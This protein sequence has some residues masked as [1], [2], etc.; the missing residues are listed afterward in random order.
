[1]ADRG[2]IEALI[3]TLYAARVDGDMEALGQVFAEHATFQIAG[4][5]EASMVA[6]L[7]EGRDNVL[8]L[9]QTMV[10]SFTIENFAILDRVIDG[11]KAAV[12]WRADIHQVAAGRTY[13]TELADFLE[14]EDGRVVSFVEF[15]DTALA[16]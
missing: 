16:G 11:G 15:L 12:R 13:T 8:A 3:E 7:A 6:T 10:D 4:S 5:P 14:I 9:I 2:D 1:M